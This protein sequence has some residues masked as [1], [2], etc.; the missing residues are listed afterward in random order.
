[1]RIIASKRSRS[2]RK[3]LVDLLRQPRRLQEKLG[4]KQ[5]VSHAIDAHHDLH[6]VFHRTCQGCTMI[7]PVIL[8]CIRQKNG[9]SPGSV[10]R[11]W[12]LSSVSSAADLNLPCVL[13][14]VWGMSSRLT[15]V[16]RVPAFTVIAPGVKA[17]LS[18]FT[19]AGVPFA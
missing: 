7:F 13:S 9:Y 5:Q 12:N 4:K 2:N 16:T 10:K 15:Q 18:I 19:S 17:K 8:G 14:T 6:V 1:M 11:N 3:V